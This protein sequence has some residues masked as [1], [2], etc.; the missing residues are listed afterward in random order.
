MTSI[1]NFSGFII[2]TDVGVSSGV[3]LP[4][5]FEHGQSPLSYQSFNEGP[6]YWMLKNIISQVSNIC[7]LLMGL[8]FRMKLGRT[9]CNTEVVVRVWLRV[10]QVFS[11]DN[12]CQKWSGRHCN[13]EAEIRLSG[14]EARSCDTIIRVALCRHQKRRQT[15][16]WWALSDVIAWSHAN[17]HL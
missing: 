3:L 13:D 5:T 9:R 17:S 2:E 4:G 7:V 11:R 1:I 12:C 10:R 6:L 15:H 16:W 14:N 8:S